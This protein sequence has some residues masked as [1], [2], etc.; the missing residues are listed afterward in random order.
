MQLLNRVIQTNMPQ[1]SIETQK[2]H[3]EDYANAKSLLFSDHTKENGFTILNRDDDHFGLMKTRSKS[4]ILTYS[5]IRD[6]ADLFIRNIEYLSGRMKINFKFQDQELEI[7]TNLTGDYQA[8]N[9]AAAVLSTDNIWR[10]SSGRNM[11][12]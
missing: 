3:I 10:R 11:R 4:E 5:M 7:I 8:Y 6:D 12:R 1:I 2:Q 9:I